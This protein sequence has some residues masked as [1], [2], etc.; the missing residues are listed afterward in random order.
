MKNNLSSLRFL[1]AFAFFALTITLSNAQKTCTSNPTTISSNINFG[2]ITWT[3]SGGATVTECNNMA[4]GVSSFTGDVIVDLANNKKITL[5]NDVT[6]NGDFPISGGNGSTLSVNGGY[7]LHVTGDLGDSGNNGVAYEVVTATDK[8]TVDGTLYGKNNNAFT[9]SGS[10]SGGTLNVKNGSSCGSPC[11]VAGGFSNC[12]AGDA[13]C[14]N[15]SV[16]PVSLISFSAKI[17]GNLVTLNWATASELNFDYFSVERSTDAVSFIEI[18]QVVGHGTTDER[19]DYLFED[20][21]PLNQKLYYRLKTVDFDGYEEYF[22]IASVD[23]GGTK[24]VSVYPNPVVGG[25]INIQLNFS[26]ESGTQIQI[27]DMVGVEKLRQFGNGNETQFSI[28]FTL[29]PGAYIIRIQSGDFNSVDR[30]LVK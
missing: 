25:S 26:P 11:P 29:D 28:P 6:I 8:I 22:N 3:A 17:D 24:Q 23:F 30:I 7:T 20:I 15:N 19:H 12:A 4:D 5:T 10:I 27:L 21:N 18:G 1:L 9:G 2:S 16:L 13:F 14:T